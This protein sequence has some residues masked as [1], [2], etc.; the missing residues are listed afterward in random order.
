MR[1]LSKHIL[2]AA[3]CSLASI[4]LTLSTPT[5]LLAQTFRGGINGT[6]TDKTGAAIS[7]ATVVAIQTDTG[8]KH[9]TTSSS[10][11]EFLFQDLPLGTYSVTASVPGFQTVKTDKISVLAGVISGAAGSTASQLTAMGLGVQKD[12]NDDQ[13]VD[14]S[15]GGF[16]GA[17]E[18]FESHQ[19][20]DCRW[21]NGL[22][23]SSAGKATRKC[24]V[25]VS[26]TSGIE[27]ALE[28]RSCW[29]EMT[30]RPARPQGTMRLK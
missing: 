29:I 9:S 28:P 26:R 7:N 17:D 27:G 5:T 23:A 15:V 12:F 3:L 14:A 25:S 16:V 24:R 6:V 10:G 13:V 11:G 21:S 2:Q 22:L 19:A 30:D 20:G 18:G 1:H 4:L 8:V